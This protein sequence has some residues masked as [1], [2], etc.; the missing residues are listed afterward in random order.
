MPNTIQIPAITIP[1]AD[2]SKM[3]L[4]DLVELADKLYM[5]HRSATRSQK[6]SLRAQYNIVANTANQKAGRNMLIHLS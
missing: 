4:M 6:K 1:A 3:H 2:A 5:Q